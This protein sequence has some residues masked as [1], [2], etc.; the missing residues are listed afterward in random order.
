MTKKKALISISPPSRQLLKRMDTSFAL[1][2]DDWN[3][4]SFRTLYHLHF[5]HGSSESDV[6]Y[7]GGVKILRQGQTAGDPQL[8]QMPFTQLSDDWV[9]VGTSLDYYQ[10]LN[11]LPPKRRTAIMEALNDVVAHPELVE[12]FQSEVGWQKSLF[13]DNKEWRE[14]LNDARALYEG[15]FTAV[16]D[17]QVSFSYTPAGAREPIQL[18]FSAPE[19]DDYFGPYNRLGPSKVRTLLPERIIILI[20]RNGSGKS[21]LLARLAHVAFASPQE[22]A[23]KEMKTLGILK[24]PAIGFTRII[25]ISYS[26]FDSFIVPGQGFKELLQT[27]RDLASGEGRFIFCGLRDLVAEARA[28]IDK[29]DAEVNSNSQDKV[30]HVERRTTTRLK[31]VEALAG[32]FAVLVKRIHKEGRGEL[33][34]AALGPLLDDPSFAELKTQMVGMTRSHKSAKSLFLGWSTGHKIALHVVA[35]LVAHTVPRSLVLFDEPEAHLHPP[36]MAALMHAVR[37]VLTDKNALCVAATHSP[38]LLQET[39]ARH[40]RIVKR[41]G[42]TLDVTKPKLETFGENVGVLTYDAFGLTA[43]T[44]DYH[45]ILDLLVQG[46]DSLEEV[47]VLFP[48]G[49]SAQA[50]AYVLAQ[51]ARKK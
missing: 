11:E 17:L 43:S 20:G 26:A 2:R 31:P 16:A 29:D 39:L 15:N 1:Q 9:S 6:T 10:R 50:R 40:V 8:I 37:I 33:L 30:S 35:S 13:R 49:L 45:K 27:T 42:E 44:T 36:L 32:E 3:D 23:T 4:H 7:I 28:D 22:R 46:C 34:E 41:T 18:D 12:R 51:F 24:P 47:E 25:T 19:P 21:T 14:F 38:V 48:S 5:K